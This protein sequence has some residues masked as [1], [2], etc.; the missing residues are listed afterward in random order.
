MQALLFFQNSQA[1]FQISG[2]TRADSSQCTLPFVLGM[3]PRPTLDASN[4][5]IACPEIPNGQDVMHS[6]FFMQQACS[7]Q[8]FYTSSLAADAIC[9]E[10]LSLAEKSTWSDWQA[11]HR[12]STWVINHYCLLNVV[13]PV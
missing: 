9:I 8:V 10:L 13:L 2:P 3:L 4:S 11:W 5:L 12:S 1:E 7:Y 6:H